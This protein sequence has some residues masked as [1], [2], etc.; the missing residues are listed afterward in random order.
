MTI[1]S[2]IPGT[3]NKYTVTYD[4]VPIATERRPLETISLAEAIRREKPLPPMGP[5][6]PSAVPGRVEIG[7][8]YE[9]F[10]DRREEGGGGKKRK[11]F[12][13]LF[14]WGKRN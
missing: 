3:V 9:D 12:R 10:D 13:I 8:G 5:M 1:G 2:P 11:G 7:A 14:K 6:S 4:G